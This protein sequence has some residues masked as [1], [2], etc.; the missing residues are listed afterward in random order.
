MTLL[1]LRLS[2]HHNGVSKLHGN[3]TRRM[4]QRLWP[5]VPADETPI[6]HITNGVHL[7]SWIS[8]E[9]NQLCDRYLTAALA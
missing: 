1:A 9:M 6:Q 5:E 4:W 8:L 2:S 7:R 3:I